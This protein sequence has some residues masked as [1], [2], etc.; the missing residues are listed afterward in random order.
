MGSAE[1]ISE[2]SKLDAV[3]MSWCKAVLKLCH[4]SWGGVLVS[5][6]QQAMSALLCTAVYLW[7]PHLEGP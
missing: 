6:R 5:R 7:N 3:V 1:A 2:V 4:W